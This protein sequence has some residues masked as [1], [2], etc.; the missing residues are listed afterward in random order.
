VRSVGGIPGVWRKGFSCEKSIGMKFWTELMGEGYAGAVVESG[1]LMTLDIA[2]PQL[3]NV[4]R[5]TRE[6]YLSNQ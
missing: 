2:K 1:A 6:Q 4:L 3:R 5:G